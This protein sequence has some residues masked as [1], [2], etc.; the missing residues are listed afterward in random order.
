MLEMNGLLA[1]N[2]QSTDDLTDVVEIARGNRDMALLSLESRRAH[3]RAHRFPGLA[4]FAAAFKPKRTLIGG[5]GG[6]PLDEFLTRPID[7]WL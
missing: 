6:V 3:R 5:G 4:A 2:G 7:Y 1:H